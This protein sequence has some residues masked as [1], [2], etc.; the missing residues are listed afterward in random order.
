VKI[1]F[2][3][4]RGSIAVPGK[5]FAEFGGNTTCIL[6]TFDHGRSAILDAG[7]GIRNVGNDMIKKGLGQQDELFILFSHMHWDHIQG[8]PFFGPAYD[9]K[10]TFILVFPNRSQSAIHLHDIFSIQMQDDFF[11]VP[12]DKMGSNIKFMEPEATRQTGA[13][14]VT[15]TP[16]KHN[17]P[18]GAY[19]YKIE[20]ENKTFVYCT[21][22]EH[23]ETI[24][25]GVV[26]L[27]RNADLLIHDAQYSPDELAVKR[28]WGHSSWEQAMDVAKK[29]NVKRLALTHHDPEHDDIYLDRVEKECQS[30]FPNTVLAREGMEIVI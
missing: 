27:S 23:G 2:Y 4:T 25:S 9:P 8:F 29:A 30:R 13:Y 24:D 12:L 1:K 7:T 18:G 19:S 14:D 6:V 20:E 26:E 15:V 5:E 11:P 21:D 3:G 16:Y 28:G 22:I 10:R 17:H